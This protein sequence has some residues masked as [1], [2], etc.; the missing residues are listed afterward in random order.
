MLRDT[1][2]NVTSPS[3]IIRAA[4]VEAVRRGFR[5]AFSSPRRPAMPDRRNGR[6]MNAGQAAREQ[7]RQGRDPEEG[8]R[9]PD[10]DE[11][12]RRS[13]LRRTGAAPRRADARSVKHDRPRRSRR[14]IEALGATLSRSASTGATRAARRAGIP[15]RHHGDDRPH[16]ERH[17]DGARAGSRAPWAAARARA[18][19][20]RLQAEREQ[21]PR[22]RSRRPS[23]PARQRSPPRSREPGSAAGSPR[24]PAAAPARASAASR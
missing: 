21:M 19:Q 22:S 2:T 7:R 23:R 8:E 11:C 13:P 14:L 6:P 15:T 17:D 10:A 4:A 5:F 16:H 20:E 1:A 12:R 24:A 3:P 9:R 18:R